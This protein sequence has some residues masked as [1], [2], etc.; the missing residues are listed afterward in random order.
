VLALVGDGG[1]GAHDLVQMTRQGGP[2]YWGGAPSRL[3]SETKRL[4]QMGYLNATAAPGR[5]HQRTV[6]RL[7]ALGRDQLRDWLVTP[8][9]F[10]RIKNEAHLRLLAGDLLTDAQ[11]V[12]SFR[13]MLTELDELEAVIEE[14]YNQADRVPARSRYLR[15]SHGYARKLVQL[16]REWIADIEAELA[17]DDSATRA[18]PQR[19]TRK[20]AQPSEPNRDRDALKDASNPGKPRGTRE[21]GAEQKRGASHPDG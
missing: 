4:A 16:H 6:Y 20:R 11:I 17:E 8:A 18:Q 21:R 19:A 5:T 14:M 9:H 3:Y 15:L 13:G 10:P 12:E 1:A 2:V 7:T